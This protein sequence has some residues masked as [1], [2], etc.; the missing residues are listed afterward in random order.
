[1][2]IANQVNEVLQLAKLGELEGHVKGVAKGF[3]FSV[4]EKLKNYSLAE[5]YNKIQQGAELSEDEGMALQAQKLLVQAYT[6]GVALN[7][8]QSNYFADL[9]AGAKQI[10]EAY[11]PKE[12]EGKEGK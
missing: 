2:E 1:M 10:T 5:L 9:N 6:R 11:K 3:D 4:P 12:S 8:C 7:S